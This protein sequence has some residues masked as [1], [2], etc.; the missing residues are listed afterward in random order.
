M[1]LQEDDFQGK[2]IVYLVALKMYATKLY[3]L[4]MKPQMVSPLTMRCKDIV[5][6]NNASKYVDP[7]PK[8]FCT[9]V[10]PP[11]V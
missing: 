10:C 6:Q 11:D 8:A 4:L 1:V 9:L 3:C 5:A 2:S 7:K